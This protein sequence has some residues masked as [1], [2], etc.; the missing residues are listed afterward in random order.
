MSDLLA[1]MGRPSR[2]GAPPPDIVD[3][4]RVEDRISFLYFE[5]CKIDRKS[6]V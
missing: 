3:L 4:V 6:V 1:G 5:H 2:R